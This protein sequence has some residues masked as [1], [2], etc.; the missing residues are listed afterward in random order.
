MRAEEQPYPQR[1][2]SDVLEDSDRI[3]GLGGI[4]I[5]KEGKRV[6]WWA[7][8][9]KEKFQMTTQKK[10]GKK[11]GCLTARGDHQQIN[12]GSKENETGGGGD[13]VST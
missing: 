1:I 9:T 7:R 6:D 10:M 8:L 13:F 4:K 3:I 5:M 12:L 2:F 11:K